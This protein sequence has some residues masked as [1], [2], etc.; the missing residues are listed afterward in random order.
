MIQLN[1]LSGKAAGSQPVVRRFPFRVGRTAENDLRLD[2]EGVWDQHLTLDC[3]R[4]EGFSLATAPNA[5]AA[6][7]H[8]PVQTARLRNGDL[9]TFG[10]VKVQFWLAAPRQRGLRLR[11]LFVWMLLAGVTAAQFALIYWLLQ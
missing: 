7:N 11:E 5:L 4:D 3:R 9:I 6:V 2:D 10:S 1:V 8:Q